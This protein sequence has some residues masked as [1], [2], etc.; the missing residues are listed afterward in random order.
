MDIVVYF[1]NFLIRWAEKIYI[2][3]KLVRTFYVFVANTSVC[4]RKTILL[5]LGIADKL[6]KWT[7]SKLYCYIAIRGRSLHF[8]TSSRKP[9]TA[10]LMFPHVNSKIRNHS[11]SNI[12]LRYPLRANPL[13]SSISP[14][15]TSSKTT[16]ISPKIPS[17]PWKINL[18][19]NYTENTI[20]NKEITHQKPSIYN[21]SIQQITS[22]INTFQPYQIHKQHHSIEVIIFYHQVYVKLTSKIHTN[23]SLITLLLNY[24]HHSHTFL[25]INL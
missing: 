17:N 15:F 4:V 9:G 12:S 23:S 8:K 22:K 1:C 5:Y 11:K 7:K 25:T 6:Q 14:L 13:K 18:L 20:F 16:T 24:I 21:P 19:S 10:H 3:S 2:F